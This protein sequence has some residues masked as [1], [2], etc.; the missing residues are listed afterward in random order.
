MSAASGSNAS[1][2][3]GGTESF[4]MSGKVVTEAAAMTA[5]RL[6]EYLPVPLAVCDPAGN[7]L[8]VNRAFAALVGGSQQRLMRQRR[9]VEALP[10]V[11]VDGLQAGD[12]R[13]TTLTVTTPTGPTP[14]EVLVARAVMTFT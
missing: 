9:L 8:S 13:T 14:M 1:N 6:V 12:H 7:L 11:R 4:S 10:G 3:N 2:V 5:W